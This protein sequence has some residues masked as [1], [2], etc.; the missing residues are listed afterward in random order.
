MY[1]RI[2]LASTL[3]PDL[4][5]LSLLSQE[6]FLAKAVVTE[7]QGG[8]KV[9]E[10]LAKLECGVACSIFEIHLSKFQN[11]NNLERELILKF[12]KV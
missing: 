2:D 1:F 7:I 6:Y 5:S 4:T 3:E 9:L 8:P 11:P 10:W 12:W